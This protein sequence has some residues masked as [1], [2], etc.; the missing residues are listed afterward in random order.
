MDEYIGIVKLYAGTFA[1][2]G[3]AYCDGQLMSIEQNS[4]LFSLL[5]TTYGGDGK[6]TFALPSLED[7]KSG[8]DAQIKYIICLSGMYPQR[9]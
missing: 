3:W 8:K 5:G 1:P 9:D 4:A 2:K 6:S 7:V